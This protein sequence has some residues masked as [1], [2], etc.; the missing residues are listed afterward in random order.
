MLKQQ[1]KQNATTPN[2]LKYHS[3]K[4]SLVTQ[5][6]VERSGILYMIRKI[7]GFEESADALIFEDVLQSKKSRENQNRQ[8]VE[9]PLEF[10]NNLRKKLLTEE[11][12]EETPPKA[13][14]THKIP[15]GSIVNRKIQ[16]KPIANAE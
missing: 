16:I 7:V 15:R 13:R 10:Y 9:N 12:N 6:G 1:Q 3:A 11:F 14:K 4:Y 5:T 2:Q 8:K